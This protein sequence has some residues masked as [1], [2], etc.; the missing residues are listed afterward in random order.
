MKPKSR[1]QRW[2]EAVAAV[3][4]AIE[5]ACQLSLDEVEDPFDEIQEAINE[6]EG[7]DLPQGFGKD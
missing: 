3:R 5:K 2:A 6:A 1:P 4:A 7:L